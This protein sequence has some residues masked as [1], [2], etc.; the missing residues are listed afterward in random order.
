[1]S[2]QAK[3]D[4]ACL[5]YEQSLLMDDRNL[6]IL[7]SYAYA[8]A[9]SGCHAEAISAYERAQ[10][11]DPSEGS[12]HYLKTASLLMTGD[13]EDALSEVE[14]GKGLGATP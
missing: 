4:K 1:M 13:L 5:A 2:L 6:S 12:T 7:C 10:T 3:F 14:K 9:R 11:L 8:L